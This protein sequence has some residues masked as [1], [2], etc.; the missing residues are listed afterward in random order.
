MLQNIYATTKRGLWGTKGT[1]GLH[2]PLP[3]LVP[4]LYAA[5]NSAYSS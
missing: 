4:V 3:W 5:E 2:L 1:A